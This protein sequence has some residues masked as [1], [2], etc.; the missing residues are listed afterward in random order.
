DRLVGCLVGAAIG[1][2]L[3]MPAHWY[4]DPDELVADFGE[5][6]GYE[7][8]KD[9]FKGSFMGRMCDPKTPAGSDALAIIGDKILF[10]KAAQ[11]QPGSTAHYHQ[12][13]VAGENTLDALVAR[14]LCRS[15]AARKKLDADDYR[16]RYIE[17]LTTPGAHNDTFAGSNHRV[18]FANRFL[19]GINPA[20]CPGND[21]LNVDGLDGL[22]SAVPI[23]VAASAAAAASADAAEAA[24]EAAAAEAAAAAAAAAA[25]GKGRAAAAAATAAAAAAAATTAAAA[26][27]SVEEV[28][29]VSA[30]VGGKL[31]VDNMACCFIDGAFRAMLHFAYSYADRGPEAMLLASANA[32]GDVSWRGSLFDL[33]LRR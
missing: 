15:L 33:A 14:L 11:W 17:L 23:I 6:R 24:A 13:M 10:G 29:Q 2:A 9:S 22:A 19:R 5:I 4:Y 1:D 16:N 25:A 26:A 31:P 12:G 3:A 28:P 18:F 7:A 32:G 20:D 21:G 8:P 30:E 27:Q